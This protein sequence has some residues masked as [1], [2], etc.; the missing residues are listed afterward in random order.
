MARDRGGP[1]LILQVLEVPA[2]DLTMSQPSIE[3]NAAG[4]MLTKESCERCRDL[5]LSDLADARNPYAS[6]LLAEDLSNLPP[7]IVMT[8]EFDP[9]RDEG[10]AY[11]ARLQ[12]AGVST[13]CTRWEGQF[14]GSQG[15]AKL[16]P[17]EAAAYQQKIIEALRR[18]YGEKP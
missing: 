5:Y 10:E 13:Q 12:K 16:I 9:L 4:P 18:A 15:M 11:A 14:H 17:D 3:E 1:N 6:P 2:T 7:A 8:M